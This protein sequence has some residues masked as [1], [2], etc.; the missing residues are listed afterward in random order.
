MSISNQECNK[1]QRTVIKFKI[2][3]FCWRNVTNFIIIN[4]AKRFIF[5]DFIQIKEFLCLNCKEQN[6]NN[7]DFTKTFG[8]NPDPFFDFL[9]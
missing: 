5:L 6:S 4:S 8:F 1:L 9:Q 3:R 2:G 7:Y